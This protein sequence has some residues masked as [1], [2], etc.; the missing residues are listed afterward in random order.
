MITKK[1]KLFLL[2]VVLPFIASAQLQGQTRSFKD[3]IQTAINDYFLPIL[4]FLFI[5]GASSGVIKNWKK[6]NNTED[7]STRKEGLQQAG[8]IALYSFLGVS[9]IGIVVGIAKALT[10]TI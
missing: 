10:I 6:I 8:M 9:V 5:L 3:I 2:T 7:E 1:N 4:I